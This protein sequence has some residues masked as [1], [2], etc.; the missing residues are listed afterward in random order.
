MSVPLFRRSLARCPDDRA[1][2]GNGKGTPDPELRTPDY[3]YFF[4]NNVPFVPPK[5]NEL[6]RAYSIFMGRLT[7]AA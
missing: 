1:D 6:D 5:P 4:I 2:S 7:F 3:W